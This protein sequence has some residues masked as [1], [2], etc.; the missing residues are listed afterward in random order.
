MIGVFRSHNVFLVP[1]CGD[2]AG[3]A[4]GGG[5]QGGDGWDGCGGD[6]NGEHDG[7]GVIA[8]TLSLMLAMLSVKVVMAEVV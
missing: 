3:G 6:G 8:V 2:G 7:L 4:A 1:A 5:G